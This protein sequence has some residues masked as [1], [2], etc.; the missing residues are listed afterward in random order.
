MHVNTS[1][2]EHPVAKAAQQAAA[3]LLGIQWHTIYGEARPGDANALIKD[4]EVIYRIIDP[5]VL[6]VGDYASSNF[7]GVDLTL[8]EGQ[9]EG[10]LEGRATWTLTDAGERLDEERREFDADPRGW[11]RAVETGVD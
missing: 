6:A 4:L 2:P 9:L 3:K 8:F 10:A 1:Q 11:S 5:L 7:N